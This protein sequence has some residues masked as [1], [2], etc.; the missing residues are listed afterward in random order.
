M[1]EVVHLNPPVDSSPAWC[2]SPGQPSPGTKPVCRPCR[3]LL[4]LTAKR[5]LKD[6]FCS[7]HAR[8]AT[9][10]LGLRAVRAV[11]DFEQG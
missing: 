9:L 11:K 5:Q 3:E 2:Q 7:K 10:Y 1:A 4:S 8:G 6:S